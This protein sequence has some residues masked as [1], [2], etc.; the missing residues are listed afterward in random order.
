MQEELI[1]LFFL[2]PHI[3]SLYAEWRTGFISNPPIQQF[4]GLD[5]DR[6]TDWRRNS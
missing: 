6:N 2:P 3:H 4:D 1:D 5:C